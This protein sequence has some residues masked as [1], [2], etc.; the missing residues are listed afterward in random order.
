[1]A[2]LL[3]DMTAILIFVAFRLVVVAAFVLPPSRTAD[4]VIDD[5]I[6]EYLRGGWTLCGDTEAMVRLDRVLKRM[7]ERDR[8]LTPSG[9][10]R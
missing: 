7:K 1:M 2:I 4:E 3:P 6:E 5:R 10:M 8:Q 9:S